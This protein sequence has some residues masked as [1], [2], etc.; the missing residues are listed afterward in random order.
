[1]AEHINKRAETRKEEHMSALLSKKRIPVW[2]DEGIF[3]SF[4]IAGSK[5]PGPAWV[6]ILGQ[7]GLILA[8]RAK[9]VLISDG[10]DSTD[11]QTF[12]VI[13]LK[14]WELD[15]RD[16]TQEYADCLAACWAL[17]AP[18]MLLSCLILN[19]YSPRELMAM[20]VSDLAIR[21]TPKYDSKQVAS[22]LVI[23]PEKY[24]GYHLNAVDADQDKPW[25]PGTGFA[26]VN[27]AFKGPDATTV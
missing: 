11:Q 27:P 21:H 22:S 24:D 23:T 13:V 3:F 4:I 6:N 1:M 8:P 12:E 25:P 5:L 26:Y 7:K 17:T 14:A 18:N 20:R 15:P 9:S 16:R 10:C 19:K 2:Q